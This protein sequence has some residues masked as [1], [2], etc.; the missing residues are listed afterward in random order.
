[1]DKALQKFKEHYSFPIKENPQEVW[2]RILEIGGDRGWY[3][4][5]RL[6]KIRGKMDAFFGGVGYRKGRKAAQELKI[7]DPIDFWRIVN[8][9]R[10]SRTIELQ[11]EMKLPGKVV[12]EW[13]V[14]ESTLTQTIQFMPDGL[15][16]KAYWFLVR[17]FHYW[18]FWNMGKKIAQG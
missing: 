18:V 7:G 5:T 8:L 16:G 3:Y 10:K 14:S 13:K 6:W 15:K 9:E 2:T 12:L 4:A 11:A 1:M 17:P